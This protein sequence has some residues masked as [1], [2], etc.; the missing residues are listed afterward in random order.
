LDLR[1][2][3]SAKVEKVKNNIEKALPNKSKMEVI[4]WASN[5]FVDKNDELV[6]TLLEIYKEIT[7]T[8]DGCIKSGGGT[9]AR[10]LPKAVAFGPVFPGYD[11][12]LH[13]PDENLRVDD[14]HRA[15]EIYKKA[16]V[17]L[18]TISN[19]Q[20]SMLNGGKK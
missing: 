13:K 20:C 7:N 1:L 8:D 5:L 10:E 16:M 12:L 19:A 17:K 2:P 6:K 9:Y 11:S 18:S 4:R 14:F 15:A 3:I